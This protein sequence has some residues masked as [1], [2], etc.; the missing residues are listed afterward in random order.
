MLLSFFLFITNASSCLGAFNIDKA[1][2]S[3]LTLVEQD[4]QNSNNSITYFITKT[5]KNLVIVNPVKLCTTCGNELSP[6]EPCLA[7][8][9]LE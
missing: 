2:N 3:S 4:I 5:Q 1:S 7:C 9:N 8:N 6:D